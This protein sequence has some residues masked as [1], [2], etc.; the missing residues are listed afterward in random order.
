MGTTFA[1]FALLGKMPLRNIKLV[2]WTSGFNIAGAKNLTVF[3]VIPSHP[4]LVFDF[5]SPIMFKISLSV[6]GCKKIVDSGTL[7]LLGWGDSGVLTELLVQIEA[8]CSLKIL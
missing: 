1:V 6:A 8:K 2:I 7:K 3:I 4:E 5:I